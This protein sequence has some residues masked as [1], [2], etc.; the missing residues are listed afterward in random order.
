[1]DGPTTQN[2]RPSK[3]TSAETRPICSESCIVRY[4]IVWKFWQLLQAYSLKWKQRCR[5]C[6]KIQLVMKLIEANPAL[7]SENESVMWLNYDV[8]ILIW[9][10]LMIWLS[11]WLIAVIALSMRF[12]LRC[13][14]TIQNDDSQSGISMRDIR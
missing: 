8:G 7:L 2:D 11:D 14:K 13:I 5:I 10:I 6:S 4:E 3:A 1:M 9:I 12:N